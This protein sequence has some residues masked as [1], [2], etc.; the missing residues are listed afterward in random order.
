[1][2]RQPPFFVDRIWPDMTIRAFTLIAIA[3]VSLAGC[4]GNDEQANNTVN[5]DQAVMSDALAANDVT[6]IDAVTGDAANMAA[7]VDVNFTN[8]MLATSNDSSSASPSPR[9]R[10]RTATPGGAVRNEATPEPAGN[11][12]ANVT[13]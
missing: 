3:T 1:M 2:C 12:A 9:S 5:I 10:A 11:A 13:E 6:A 8:E 4:G 7:D